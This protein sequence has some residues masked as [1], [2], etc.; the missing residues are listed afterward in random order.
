[1]SSTTSSS[2]HGCGGHELTCDEVRERF[3]DDHIEAPR[4]VIELEFECESGSED[5]CDA[6]G[7]FL[8]GGA[9][10]EQDVSRGT[11]LLAAACEREQLEACLHVGRFIQARQAN[12]RH[13]EAALRAMTRA[14]DAGSAEGCSLAGDMVARGRGT[15][16]DRERAL[17]FRRRACDGGSDAGCRAV[18][19]HFMA[20]GDHASIVEVYRGMC[21]A[22]RV[23]GCTLLAELF[24]RGDNA[25]EHAELASLLDRGCAGDDETACAR[26]GAYL[27][28]GTFGVAPN[29]GRARE[30]LDHACDAE[31]WGAC[32]RLG[33]LYERGVGGV[34]RRRHARELYERACEH[35]SGLACYHLAHPR[36]RGR[37][38]ASSTTLGR[39]RLSCESGEIDEAC[40]DYARAMQSAGNAAP[41]TIAGLFHRGCDGGDASSCVALAELLTSGEGVAHD[42]NRAHAF[43][44]RACALEPDEDRCRTHDV[45]RRSFAGRVSEGTGRGAPAEETACEL[46]LT[47]RMDGGRCFVRLTCGER[48]LYGSEGAWAPC[49]VRGRHVTIRDFRTSPWDGTPQLFVD[50]RHHL[51]RLSDVSGR[52]RA[53][54]V[55]M[56][57]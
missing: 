50:T 25:D 55:T 17:T 14:C 11:E 27:A 41:D 2:S 4:V 31:D 29:P 49:D 32:A 43:E 18:A 42:R 1:M 48:D 30:L 38:A 45:R 28:E 57:L 19:E 47:R 37:R 3:Y 24:S 15:D 46:E 35:R 5:A 54:S 36:A 22:G 44:E 33:V 34:R 16:R 10:V 23:R 20:V 39:L 13:D 6:Y 51:V 40:G 8:L 56:A 7:F 12:A 26:L 52:P 53:M 9:E 21:E